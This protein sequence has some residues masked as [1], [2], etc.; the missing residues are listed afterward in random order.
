MKRFK[1]ISILSLFL[2]SSCSLFNEDMKLKVKYVEKGST[3][4]HDIGATIVYGENF[5]FGHFVLYKIT[6]SGT[7]KIDS[8]YKVTFSTSSGLTEE[9]FKSSKPEVGEYG[10][11]FEYK[12]KF[13]GM[14]FRVNKNPTLPSNISMSMEDW[15]FL[16]DKKQPTFYNYTV[17]ENTNIYYTI[18]A[19]NPERNYGTIF[20]DDGY[21]VMLDPGQYRIMATISD[22]HFIGASVSCEFN[23]NKIDFPT[24]I[25]EIYE[26]NFDYY[27]S[28][29]NY[30][31]EG[32]TIESPRV[33][34]K[35][36]KE[37]LNVPQEL[38]YL[39]WKDSTETI[40]TDEITQ[41]KVILHTNYF[42][43]YEYE[44]NVKVRK[45]EVETPGGI[46]IDDFQQA[47]GTYVKYDGNEHQIHIF[48][49]G[50]FGQ[51]EI[52][53]ETSTV[54]ATEKGV[55]HVYIRLVDKVNLLWDDTHNNTDKHFTWTIGS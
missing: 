18:F 26:P 44:V 41:H 51:Y 13:T 28:I 4:E 10:F 23:V 32:Y 29:N 19:L 1:L 48:H 34:F 45:T 49:T 27:F 7:S 14:T 16:G 36:T 54:R 11:S 53:E 6:N 37:N 52:D 24:D 5:N 8:G 3:E 30:T 55:Y 47:L 20:L 46:Y 15:D 39:T 50:Y 31:L 43:D 2:L 40:S 38:F 12:G 17:T 9:I 21:R 42:N 33:R 35:D 25:L 22:E